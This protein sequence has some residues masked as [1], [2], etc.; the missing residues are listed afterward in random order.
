MR[1]KRKRETLT[2][3]F[4]A[5]KQTNPQNAGLLEIFAREPTTNPN[6][7]LLFPEESVC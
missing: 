4:R 1:S 6:T 5:T 7:T 3:E 2:V